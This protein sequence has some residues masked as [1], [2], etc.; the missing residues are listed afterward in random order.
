MSNKPLSPQ[1]RNHFLN[2]RCTPYLS[3][4]LFDVTIT[5]R[6]AVGCYALPF[7]GEGNLQFYCLISQVPCV[8]YVPCVLYVPYKKPQTEFKMR[9]L[10]YLV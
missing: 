6:V 2:P 8:P 5:H 9:E 1:N 4:R 7:Q 10:F 3:G